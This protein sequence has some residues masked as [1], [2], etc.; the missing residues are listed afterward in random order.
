MDGNPDASRSPN[1]AICNLARCRGGLLRAVP[2]AALEDFSNAGS[3][4]RMGAVFS[5]RA[6][7]VSVR[8]ADRLV[9]QHLLP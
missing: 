9:E 8:P 4:Y 6:I 7:A 1:A 3:K 2:T 5:E